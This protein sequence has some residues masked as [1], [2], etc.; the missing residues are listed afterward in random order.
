MTLYLVDW[1]GHLRLEEPAVWKC[2][3]CLK[4]NAGRFPGR[5]RT[6]VAGVEEGERPIDHDL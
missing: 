6:V 1:H 3:Q 4:E 2:P 5:L